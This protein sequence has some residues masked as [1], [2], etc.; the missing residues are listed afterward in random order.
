[1]VLTEPF[2]AKIANNNFDIMPTLHADSVGIH[3]L[4]LKH[5]WYIALLI[6]D[7]Q[8]RP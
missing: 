5:S 7:K 2:L 3:I 4:G 8:M 1:M 6:R